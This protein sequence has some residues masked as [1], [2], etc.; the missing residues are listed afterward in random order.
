SPKINITSVNEADPNFPGQPNLALAHFTTLL[1]ANIK[2][3]VR[4]ADD[5]V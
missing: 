1:A 5:R 4:L 2:V 3:K